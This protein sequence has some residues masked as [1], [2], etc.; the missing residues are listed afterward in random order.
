MAC[1]IAKY[2]LRTTS[3]YPPY[4]LCTA[5]SSADAMLSQYPL[6]RFIVGKVSTGP[7]S[8]IDH[9]FLDRNPKYRT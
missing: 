2:C 6:L 1:N 5:D 9:N 8:G 3:V 4:R 7:A